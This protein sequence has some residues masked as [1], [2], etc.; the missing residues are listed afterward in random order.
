M[1]SWCTRRFVLSILAFIGVVSLHAQTIVPL[2]IATDS[3]PQVTARIVALDNAGMPQGLS[4]ADVIVSDNGVE[5]TITPSCDASTSGRNLSLVV[6]VDASLSMSSSGSPTSM[7]LAKNAA[8]GIT[9]L[10]TST[11]DEIALVQLSS[12]AQMLYGLSTNKTAYSSSVDAMVVK[13]GM[14]SGKGLTDIPYGALTHLQNARNA[15]ALVLI[16][17]GA[18]LFDVKSAIASARTFGIAVYVVCLRSSIN[19][20]M[21]MLAD[22]TNGSWCEQIQTIAD[23]Q[24]FAR[25]FV[26]D[27]KRLPGCTVT[28]K[29]TSVCDLSHTVVLTRGAA[30]RTAGYAVQKEQTVYLESNVTGIEFGTVSTGSKLVRSVTVTARYGAVTIDGIGNFTS[31]SFQVV[32]APRFPVTLQA[33]ASLTLSI[34]YTAASDVG[35]YDRLTYSSSGSCSSPVIHVHGGNARS[36]DVLELIG[37]NGGE[38]LLA[39]QDTTIRWKNA[40]P[41]DFVRIEVS[42][43]DGATWSSLTENAQGLSY[44]WRPGPQ[45]SNQ[46]RIRVA[47]TVIDPNDIVVMRGQDQPVYASIFTED[48]KHVITG[49]HDGSVRIWSAQD[50][51]QERI[52]GLHGNWVW[53]LSQKPGTTIVASASHDGS[54]R[55]WDYTNGQRIATI[56]A[57]G[58]VWSLAF[59][60]DGNKLYA[61]TDR[62]IAEINSASWTIFTSRI[63]DQGPVYNLKLVGSGQQLAVAEGSQA[64]VRDIKSLDV[65]RVFK[66]PGA[67]EQ[68]YAVAVNP[69]GTEIASGGADLRVQ[70]YKISDGSVVKALPPMKGGVLA[71]DYSSNG[72]TLLVAGGDG[73]AKTYAASTLDL[74]TSLAG[75]NGILYSGS[76]SPDGKRVVTSSTDFTARVW[77]LERIGSTND[78]SDRAFAITG[79]VRE[80]SPQFMGDVIVG[81]GTDARKVVVTNKDAAPLV[82][83]GVRVGSGDTTDFAILDAAV[84][85]LVTSAAPYSVDIAFTPTTAGPREA[86]LT[87]ESGMGTFSVLITGNGVVSP[88]SAPSVIDY[89]RRVAN[90]SVVDSIIT[91]RAS[92]SLQAPVQ[93]ASMTILGEQA[94]QY[95]IV[96]GGGSVSIQPGQTHKITVRFDPTNYG[97]F[98]AALELRITGGQSITIGLYGEA[99]GD[100]RIAS[101]SNTLLFPTGTCRYST[102][103]MPFDLRNSGNT[104]LQVYSVGIDGA[105]ADEFSV[106]SADTY[107]ITIAPNSSK[108]FVVT[109]SPNRVGVKDARVVIS[110]SAINASNGRTTISMSARKD[111]VGFELSR[112]ELDFGNV[113][114]NTVVSERI[115]LLNTGTISLKWPR[116]SVTVGRFQID[117]ITPDIT[118]GGKRSDMTIR[119]LGGRSGETYDTT[120]EFI[121]TI[122]GRKQSIRLRATVKSYIGA[123]IEID[124]VYTQTGS[125]VSVPVYVKSL[126]NFDRTSVRS[127]TGHFRVNGTLLSAA[128]NV[129][130]A[131][132]NDNGD[133]TFDAPIPIP[134]VE[135]LSTTLTFSTAWGNDTASFVRIDSLTFTDTLTFRTI[136]G[137]VILTDICKQG[138]Q[139]RLVKL[140]A[141]SAGITIGPNPTRDI[142]QLQISASETGLTTVQL[143]SVSGAHISTLLHA[144]LRPGIWS[145]ELDVSSMPIGSYFMVMSTPTETI[146]RRMEVVR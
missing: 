83:T 30:S 45:K 80:S 106:S 142:A 38:T 21:K 127:I 134:T 52:V 139:A 14:N 112:S 48:G 19:A 31:S 39:G 81:Y 37:P 57:E 95:S 53:S 28:W 58:R 92:G 87:F 8:R 10:L 141:Q 6:A 34:E 3:F 122:C 68:Q 132:L 84:P 9:Q 22:S 7:D 5:Q 86:Y 27:A 78:I 133:L 100:G 140:G 66:Q 54:V 116:N 63:V 104:E 126:V 129:A 17:D 51:S 72:V 26:A 70:V 130:N 89:G 35:I 69:A 12:S 91:I 43:D 61:G 145:Q 128:N 20:D 98:A 33:N 11:A 49:G 44:V 144:N 131:K 50:G 114:E 29:T 40:L 118:G 67:T 120:Y 94:G 71:L 13:G 24:A 103:Q 77:S 115:L 47:R 85:A 125:L 111:S 105:N 90:Q 108:S 46:A 56:P 88:L 138:G 102:S 23:A 93:I 109:F 59:S 74:Q 15:R 76:F 64:T 41:D 107:P 25:A 18:S 137:A 2:R 123:T 121:D 119:F 16:T 36:G 73:T 79:G 117:S 136:G 96:D 146:T 4:G 110:S 62:G 65:V 82:I 1:G 99:T 143:F 75:H 60:R 101:S 135:G 42:Y 55:I 113:P 97:R 124:T 32:G